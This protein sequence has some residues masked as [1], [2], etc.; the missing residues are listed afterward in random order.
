[1]LEL[2][3]VFHQVAVLLALCAVIGVVATRLRQPLIVGFIA[4]GI[5]VGPAGLGIVEES[6]EIDLLATIGIALLLFVVGLKLDVRLI[7]TVGPVALATGIG[8]M[9]VTAGIGYALCRALGLGTVAALYVAVALTFS[10]TVIIVKMLSDSGEIEDLHGRIA[11]GILI[12]QDIVVVVTMIAL[13]AFSVSGDTALGGQVAGVVVRGAAFIGGL[14]LLARLVL[15]SLLHYLARSAE[16]LVLF[17]IAWAVLL[18]SAGELMGFSEEVGA[19]M[20]GISLASTPYREALGARLVSLRDFLLLFFFI[21]LG[22]QLDVSNAGEQLVAVVVL[23]LF[24]LLGKP[25]SV[26]V[27]MGLMRYP[28]R[29]SFRTGLS[30]AQISEFSLILV[31]LGA[32]LGHI[33]GDAVGL[34][35]TVGLV[36]IALSTYLISGSAPL[37]GR[38]AGALAVF[39]R[40]GAANRAISQAGDGPPPDVAV[41]GLGRYGS[42]LVAAFQAGGYTPL[43]IDFNPAALRRWQEQGLTVRYGDAY[44]P[45]IVHL[46]PLEHLRWVVSSV[47][48]V[49]TNLA[50][51]QVLAQHG[52]QGRTAVTALSEQDAHILEDAGADTVL[53]PFADAAHDAVAAMMGKEPP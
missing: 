14:A 4:A 15:P 5:L 47:R 38:L 33:G 13:S 34:V 24:V 30:L 48:D 39:E 16:L 7:R 11:I 37:Y 35:T 36:T 17:A 28:T 40:A 50:L 19:F 2:E 21:T 51:V 42:N 23:S 49:D 8:Q 41:L 43:G 25:L 31:A 44:D 52:Y 26:I 20:A 3:T 12:V 29:V 18:A 32:D 22:V 53:R 27:T 45:M 1:M 9:A 10:S 6:A 46:L